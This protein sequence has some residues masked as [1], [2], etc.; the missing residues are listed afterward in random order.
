MPTPALTPRQLLALLLA[1]LASV[2]VTVAIVDSDG[3][4][5]PDHVTITLGPAAHERADVPNT[6][7][8]PAAAIAAAAAGD[9][10]DGARNEAPAIAEPIE[11]AKA[12]AQ[13]QRL[14]ATDQLPRVHPLAA[15]EQDGCRSRFV[16]NYSSRGGVRPRLFVLHYTVSPNRPGWSD[17]DGITGYFSRRDIGASSH[18]VVDDEANCNYIVRESDKAWT[19][20]AA[21]PVSISVE[22]IATGKE[23]AYTSPEGFRL[24][25][26]IYNDAARRWDIPLQRGEVRGCTIIRPGIVQHADFGACGG[27]HHDINPFGEPAIQRVLAEARKHRTGGITPV[28]KVTCRKLNWWRANGRP[29]GGL[30]ERRAVMRRRALDARGVTCTPNGPVRR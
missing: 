6:M 15:P 28:D 14:A 20:A 17:V 21:N 5:R 26:R 16:A 11:I 29:K 9:L 8:V 24:L 27:G 3:D 7:R 19:Q 25:G 4:Q 1:L 2:T 18:Y 12:R 23:A 13:Q 10:H 22:Q 30:P